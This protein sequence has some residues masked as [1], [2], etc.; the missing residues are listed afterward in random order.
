[1]IEFTLFI[2]RLLFLSIFCNFFYLSYGQSGFYTTKSTGYEGITIEFGTGISNAS[3]CRVKMKDT[4]LTFSPAEVIS[5]G[6][7]GEKVYYSK[8]VNY[9]NTTQKYFLERINN[10]KINLY[11]L[12]T[13]AG[14]TFYIERDSTLFFELKKKDEKKNNIYKEQLLE[15]TSDFPEIAS[16]INFVHYNRAALARFFNDYNQGNNRLFPRFRTGILAVWENTTLHI[17]P[18]YRSSAYQLMDNKQESSFGFGVFADVPIMVSYFSFHTELHLI[19]HAFSH[20]NY[21]DNQEIDFAANITSLKIPVLCRYT[22]ANRK[23][24]PFINAGGILSYNFRKKG[25]TYITSFQDNIIEINT[26]NNNSLFPN[27]QTGATAGLGIE[28]QVNSRH[29]VFFEL[30]YN[31]LIKQESKQTINNSDLQVVTAINF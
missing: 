11:F 18:I 25:E 22:F 24:S 6:I 20:Y 10:G 8:E 4:V 13:K 23:I 5:Y 12:A 31:R 17:P 7:R 21:A 19:K 28:Y 16:N 2:K 1:M 26:A 9:G 3:E 14:Q 30:R 29:S 27:F 15:I